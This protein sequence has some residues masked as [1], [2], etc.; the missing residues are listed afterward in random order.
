MTGAAGRIGRV[1]S[2]GLTELGYDVMGVDLTDAEGV[3]QVD[4]REVDALRPMLDG[5][6]AVVH[7][8]GFPGER[9]LGT[10]LDTHVQTTY[11]V[12]EAMRRAGVPRMVF[13][14]SHHAV[15]FAPSS[16]HLGVDARPRPDTFYGVG[17]AAAETL[18]SLYCDRYEMTVACLRIGAFRDRPSTRSQLRTWLSPGDAVRLVHACL[19][20]PDLTYA[21][22]YGTSANT[23][24]WY[25]LAPARALG[26]EPQDD[27]EDY[28][29]EIL[30]TPESEDDVFEARFAGGRFCRVP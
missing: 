23:R 11:G 18:C 8:A 29:A 14:S 28:A 19:T 21:V 20:A 24:G 2:A 30:D 7:L 6:S 22:L 15:G 17:K 9:D 16:D 4:V 12:L 1:V 27:A 10:A 3:N 13:A 5:C 25:D 26:Y